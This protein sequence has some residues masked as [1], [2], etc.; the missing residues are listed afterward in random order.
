LVR[1]WTGSDG[2]SLLD[3]RKTA[4]WRVSTTRYQGIGNMPH[5]HSVAMG[6]SADKR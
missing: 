3:L 4:S 6:A 5:G 1:T 2:Q